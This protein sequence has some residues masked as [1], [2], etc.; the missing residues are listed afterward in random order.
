M[1]FV[2]VLSHFDSGEIIEANSAYAYVTDLM[3]TA[4]M[5]RRGIG[6]Q[7]LRE[8]EAFAVRQGA[9][10]IR[11]GVL[12]RN[13]VARSIYMKAGFRELDVELSKNLSEP[14]AANKPVC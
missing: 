10:V 14:R 12:A 7:V 13:I 4:S 9:T 6:R 1:G 2:C 5:R 11:V 8:A 3:V